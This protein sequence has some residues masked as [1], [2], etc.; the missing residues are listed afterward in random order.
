[1]WLGSIWL[2]CKVPSFVT[3]AL[4]FG[5]PLIQPLQRAYRA[6]CLEWGVASRLST[7]SRHGVSTSCLMLQP[8]I[9]KYSMPVSWHSPA[10]SHLAFSFSV[11]AELHCKSVLYLPEFGWQFSSAVTSSPILFS[12]MG[13]P[14]FYSS[15]TISVGLQEA[16]TVKGY[17][18]CIT[19]N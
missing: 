17:V 11:S 14:S 3:G 10:S 5:D 8:Y 18:Q 19:F 9:L 4:E 7:Q 6:V 12:L 13:L 1:M 15:V 16:M 2:G